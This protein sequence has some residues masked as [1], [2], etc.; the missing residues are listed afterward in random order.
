[1]KQVL[2]LAVLFWFAH[3]VVSA[4]TITFEFVP[5]YPA[6]ID[7]MVISNQYA[8]EFG[9]SFRY[10]DGSYPQLAK[11]GA[12]RTAFQGPNDGDDNAKLNQGCGDFFLTDD[13]VV[14]TAPPPLIITY[15]SPVAAASGVI[16]DID[17]T[18]AFGGNERWLLEARGAGD[19]LLATNRLGVAAFNSGDGL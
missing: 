9:V 3:G 2:R 16:I 7:Q 8:A 12:P 13:G 11:R 15:S 4:Q 1:M 5:G 18:P 19:V 6:P 14:S 17:S 10:E